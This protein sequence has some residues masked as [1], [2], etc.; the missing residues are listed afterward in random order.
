M[1]LKH[2]LVKQMPSLKKKYLKYNSYKNQTV[3]DIFNSE[4]INSSIVNYIYNLETAIFIND[5]SSFN[6]IEIPIESQFSTT[7]AIHV[8]DYNNDGYKDIIIGGNLYDVKP[9]VG[10]YDAQYGL[11]LL[12]NKEGFIST[13]NNFS[14][15]SFKGQ[16]RE[17]LKLKRNRENILFVLNNNDK[18]QS[19]IY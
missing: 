4:K 3:Y 11:L 10:R 12:G 9:E 1:S 5:S 7:N 18:L 17:L 8:D 6:K 19:F 2:D 13:N 14:G 16:T 15:V